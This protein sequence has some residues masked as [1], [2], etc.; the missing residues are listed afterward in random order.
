MKTGPLVRLILL[1][2]A[3]L[4]PAGVAAA[5]DW[6]QWRGANRDGIVTHF[7]APATWTADSLSK[8][9]T[10]TVGEGHSSPVVVA[11]SCVREAGATQRPAATWVRAGNAAVA[12]ARRARRSGTRR[13]APAAVTP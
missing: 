10:L 7:K 11:V 2:F 9:W 1:I 4:L 3:A 5:S 6:N 12:R 8:K 13:T